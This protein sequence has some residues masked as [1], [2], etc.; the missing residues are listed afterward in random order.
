MQCWIVLQL[1][2]Q[3]GPQYWQIPPPETKSVLLSPNDS[4]RLRTQP[5]PFH[6]LLLSFPELIRLGAEKKTRSLSLGIY[7]SLASLSL[8]PPRNAHKAPPSILSFLF[9][10][11]RYRGCFGLKYN[12]MVGARNGSDP[13]SSVSISAGK[14]RK[15]TLLDKTP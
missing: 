3:L 13:F 5:P 9:C 15:K 10:N 1:L 12:N 7:R 6:P 2:L 8:P 4:C 14:R 11:C